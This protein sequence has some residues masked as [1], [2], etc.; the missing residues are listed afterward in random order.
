ML[1]SLLFLDPENLNDEVKIGQ[2]RLLW[3]I[4]LWRENYK[5]S[6]FLVVDL[7]II[8]EITLPNSH[9]RHGS[10]DVIFFMIY[11]VF[12]LTYFSFFSRFRWVFWCEFLM[13][14]NWT[15]VLWKFIWWSPG[16]SLECLRIQVNFDFNI[17]YSILTENLKIYGIFR[18][19]F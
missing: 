5:F 16:D 4:V 19:K 2:L 14:C 3:K 12:L 7:I 13:I 10:V 15:I 18:I 9:W 6:S 1:H 11:Q 17:V 8:M